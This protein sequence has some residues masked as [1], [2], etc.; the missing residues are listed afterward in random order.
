MVYGF[1]P[2]II[3]LLPAIAFAFYAQG[4][5]NRAYK[6]YS[7][8]RNRKGITGA[9]AARLI[10][11]RNGLAGVGIE[12]TRGRL[13][14]NYDPKTKKLRLSSDVYGSASIAAVG[15]AAHEAGHALQHA[16]RYKPLSIRNAIVPVVNIGSFLS[17]PLLIIGIAVISAGYHFEGNL[18][19]DLGVIFF[20]GVLVFH[21]VTLPVEFNASRRAMRQLEDYGVIFYEERSGAK[22]VLAAA[23][24]TYVAALAVAVANLLRILMIR[25]D[26]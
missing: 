10:L 1:D 18:I 3:V 22:K 17:W 11:D 26:R 25:G 6:V 14:D 4:K 15:I 8:V 2:T 9:Q 20:L 16:K 12:L 13:T 21:A 24:M 7:K 5:V 23:A 19:F